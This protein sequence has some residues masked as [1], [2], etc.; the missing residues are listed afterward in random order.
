MSERLKQVLFIVFFILFSIGVAFAIWWVFFREA[1]TVTEP[2]APGEG[3]EGALP[4]AGE[5]G[6]V[7]G[8]PGAPEVGALP[9]AGVVPGAAPTRVAVG[10]TII[11]RDGITQQASGSSDGNGARFYNPDDS[12]FYRVTADGR[13]IALS[14][15]TFPNVQT[16]SWG[17]TSD[18][19]ILEF[20]D[21]T[22]V[23]YDFESK[24]QTT[25]PK[26]WEGFEFAGDDNNIVAKSNP[27]IP[28]N[29]YLIVADPNGGNPRAIEPLGEN[30]D[31]TF[32]YWTPND[33]II[34]YATVGDPSGFDRQ[35]II[36]VGQEHE[37]FKGLLVE[38][39]DFMPLWSPSGQIVLYSVW[40]G[41][42]D[43]KPEL[44][45]SGGAPDNVNENRRK[46]GLQTWADK[47]VWANE[48]TLY[49]AVPDALPRG[50]GLDSSLFNNTRDSI[51]RID[52]RSGSTALIG[53]P[54]GNLNV[55]M[56]VLSDNG[57]ILIFTDGIT[58]SLYSFRV[59]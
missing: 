1:P 48:E 5:A 18:Q 15:E 9:G 32:P 26:H 23:H 40:N 30:D 57:S 22:N 38:G 11:L 8:V 56:P 58:G 33:Q 59:L 52:L 25:L 6:P 31:K 27:S 45:I 50:A 21:G 55:R 13:T 43:Y 47:C 29:R 16:V 34:A 49:C 19:A 10:E 46:I 53:A 2:V 54:E 14:D 37:N 4:G 42:S 17:N 39:R 51:Y 36:L 24:K 28:D 41:E 20:P 7:T 35:T 44:W 3:L 12:K